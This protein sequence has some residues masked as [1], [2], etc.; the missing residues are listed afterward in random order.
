MVR[1][2]KVGKGIGLGVAG[3]FGLF[4]LAIVVDETVHRYRIYAAGGD[5]CVTFRPD[6]SH[7]IQYGADCGYDDIP[8]EEQ[9]SSSML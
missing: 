5:W 9:G 7:R 8:P 4:L 1:W 2:N 6:G 3:L